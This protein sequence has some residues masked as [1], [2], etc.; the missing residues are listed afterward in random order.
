MIYLSFDCCQCDRIGQFI[1]LWA[2]FQSL[3]QQLIC[4]NLLHSKAIFLKV[5]KSLFFRVKSFLG[6]FID[7][8]RLFTCHT[9][10]CYQWWKIIIE[11][12]DD[13]WTP[14]PREFGEKNSTGNSS[15]SFS[16]PNHVKHANDNDWGNR[17]RRSDSAVWPDVGID[18]CPI[19]SPKVAQKQRQKV[20][21]ECP[22]QICTNVWQIFGLLLYQNLSPRT[23][24]NRPIW[25]HWNCRTHPDQWGQD[26]KTFCQHLHVLIMEST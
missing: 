6:N 3:W 4:P 12:S 9:D 21:L 8:W 13:N 25:S 18:G 24:K 10:C 20:L 1:G 16:N 22:F 26:C 23:F 2:T 17:E 19:F 11:P 14:P 7:I 15:Q 5:S